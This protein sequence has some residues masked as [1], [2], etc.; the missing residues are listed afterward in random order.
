MIHQPTA[1]KKQAAL[2]LSSLSISLTMICA[3]VSAQTNQPSRTTTV[4]GSTPKT[5]AQPQP[6]QDQPNIQI[7]VPQRLEGLGVAFE[8]PEG[9]RTAN[10][11]VGTIQRTR[12]TPPDLSWALEVMMLIDDPTLTPSQVADRAIQ[13][14]T[15]TRTMPAW[16]GTPLKV[17]DLGN[18]VLLRQGGMAVP[19]GVTDRPYERFRLQ[20]SPDNV[21]N[22]FHIRDQ[23]QFPSGN[24]S[25]IIFDF[26]TTKSVSSQT[27]PV[28]ER[29]LRTVNFEDVRK[30]A[31]KRA[32][33]IEE[34]QRLFELL[35]NQGVEAVFEEL[36]RSGEEWHRFY[37][38]DPTNAI[39]GKRE[40]GYRRIRGRLGRRSDLDTIFGRQGLVNPNPNGYVFQ[41]EARVM[42]DE[43][44][45][46]VISAFFVSDDSTVEKQIEEWSIV[47]SH[48]VKIGARPLTSR[49]FGSREGISISVIKEQPNNPA[50]HINAM[51]EGKGY[52][53]QALVYVL[54][55]LLVN[56]GAQANVAFYAYV[57]DLK[58][59]KLRFD[60]I[61]RTEDGTWS[62]RSKA[63]ENQPEYTSF[64]APDGSFIRTE[65][66]D[67]RIC[68]PTT[69]DQLL[70]IW[71]RKGLPLG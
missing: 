70:A 1:S 15:R 53:S 57:P 16:D 6:A 29:V 34:G 68:E 30:V 27:L 47:T 40:F 49:E 36:E 62:I 24:G 28:F 63:T 31:M 35:G 21:Q 20:L 44:Y 69:K 8:V 9:T 67:G 7:W 3:A 26:W 41:M 39:D 56:A 14:L 51:I 50:E 5:L 18:S 65:Y 48:T 32:A 71:K 64:Y 13:N 43:G 58:T 23:V 52:L 17:S 12:I 59:N 42:L 54:P 19:G 37:M 2:F 45:V 22:D 66:A 61:E 60:S 33:G 10:E 11:R 25:Y 46:D 55:R 38:P 4:T